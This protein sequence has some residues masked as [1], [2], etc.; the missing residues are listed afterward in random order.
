MHE[1]ASRRLEEMKLSKQ[2]MVDLDKAKNKKIK[3]R[4]P[5]EVI[6]EDNE[7][8]NNKELVAEEN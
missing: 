4:P 7:S 6:M 3:R 8:E 5:V 2:T 1:A